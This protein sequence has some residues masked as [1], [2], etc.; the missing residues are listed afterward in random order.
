LLR[1][2]T[3]FILWALI[4][5][6]PSHGLAGDFVEDPSGGGAP[7]TSESGGDSTFDPFSDYSEFEEGS[8]EEADINFFHNGRFF[9]IG[10]LGGYESFTDSLSGLYSPGFQFGG[11]IEYFFDLKLAM[12]LAYITANHTVTL[13]PG[14]AAPI[15]NVTR[16]LAAL[17]PYLIFGG[18]TY[19]RQT[20]LNFNGTAPVNDS[21]F[22]AQGGLGIE[23]PMFHNS[24]FFGV[25]GTYNYIAFPATPNSFYG[26]TITFTGN[27]I[28]ILGMVGMSF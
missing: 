20:N 25:Q 18:A 27:A 11:F 19:S 5:A 7:S 8:D 14:T 13:D 1:F 26:Q 23:I 2:T 6:K 22:G 10:I 12:E 28:S 15:Q 3:L 16:G 24:S 17:N 9:S 4:I 21:A